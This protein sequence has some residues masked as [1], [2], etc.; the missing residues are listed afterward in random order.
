MGIILIYIKS[1]KILQFSKGSSF[2]ASLLVKAGHAT[3]AAFICAL[4]LIAAGLGVHIYGSGK[5][6]VSA[7]AVLFFAAGLTIMTADVMMPLPEAAEDLTV[8][9]MVSDVRQTDD[10]TTVVAETEEYGRVLITS[11][12]DIED[13]AGLCGRPVIVTGDIGPART[14]SNP[15]C[16][17]YRLYLRGRKILSV[18]KAGKIQA[19]PVKRQF[20][21]KL[22][23]Y[24]ADVRSKISGSMSE[25]GAALL[26]AMLF[27]DKSDLDDDVYESF[28]KNGTAHIL[29]V[30]GL[31]VGM[32]YA[33]LTVLLGGR[34][35]TGRNIVILLILACYTVMA[36]CAPS[37]VRAVI[38]ISL[39]IAAS[40]T[41][42]RYDMLTAASAAALL[43]L[44]YEPYALFS[45]GFQMSFLAIAAISF[46]M[47]LIEIKR[48]AGKMKKLIMPAVLMQLATAPYTAY[49]FNCFSA[50][51]F[52]ANIPVIY[53]AG[54]IVPAGVMLT[55]SVP[56]SEH[57]SAFSAGFADLACSLMMRCN[58]L[59]YHENITSFDVES[60]PLAFV[61]IYY[62]VLFGMTS[63]TF[64]LAVL[65]RE[66]AKTAIVLLTTILCIL[67][68]SA[69]FT[70]RFL[71]AECV[72]VDV[73]QGACVH[74]RTPEG[75]NILIDGGGRPSFGDEE[76]FDVG[77]KIL[78]PYLLKNKAGHVDIAM[79]THLDADHYQGITTI[80]REGMVGKL[81]LHDCLEDEKERIMNDTGMKEEDIVFLSTGST[82][83]EAGFSLEI[84]GPVTVGESENA[85]S[86]VLRCAYG[87]KHILIAGD[88]DKDEESDMVSAYSKT[89]KLQCDIMQ[90]PH[91]GSGYSS[92]DIF[93]D[94]VRPQAAV[95]QVG[96]NNYGH[97]SPG[98]LERLN[99]HGIMIFR[100][101]T[102]GA[103]GA[104]ITGDGTG[105]TIIMETVME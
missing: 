66:K 4:L 94:A 24:R 54:L 70:N 105:R 21:N 51:A 75:K 79:V 13:A 58:D 33:L 97:P 103:V 45:S 89:G 50:G 42:R 6:A 80:C 102:D 55:V 37:I 91:H 64:R 10:K 30:S 26:T 22:S 83:K 84:I 5:N 23:V 57:I 68:I 44:L 63:E 100:N 61:L 31:H 99:E 48:P 27:G 46:L 96:K 90:V 38:M 86:L 92:S 12:D 104:D 71:D 39:H 62:S 16:F 101:D 29:A 8:K 69:S 14:R 7:A 25:D 19:G 87:D 56:F 49:V 81:V 43:M 77:K 65:R 74:L 95:I 53:L 76:S 20:L 18:M 11:Y 34:R 1:E 40:L 35:K 72:F 52:I 32:I 2:G 9:G 98:T 17:D 15:G 67:G 59:F 3:E 36:G 41:H 73:G 78:M 60:P 93:L 88:A 82:I 85:N 47:P 28:R